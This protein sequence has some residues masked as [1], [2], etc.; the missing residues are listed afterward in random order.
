[1]A[2]STCTES[3][4]WNLFGPPHIGW[5]IASNCRDWNVWRWWNGSTWSLPV[6]PCEGEE[7]AAQMAYKVS[8]GQQYIAWTDYY[9]ANARVPRV[10]P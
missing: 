6:G 2:E 8:D 3:L 9:P 5:W 7:R 4:K 1:M 10:A